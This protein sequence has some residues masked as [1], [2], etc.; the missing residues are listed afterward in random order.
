MFTQIEAR[1]LKNRTKRG[2][3]RRF[4]KLVT[5]IRERGG[6]AALQGLEQIP[7]DKPIPSFFL[8]PIIN[9]VRRKSK[10]EK[11]IEESEP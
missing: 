11:P 8:S 10:I 9:D 1:S 6:K 7:L 4:G 5:G 2:K 3:W